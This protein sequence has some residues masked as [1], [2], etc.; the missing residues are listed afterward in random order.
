MR[1]LAATLAVALGS[2]AAALLAGA[3]AAVASPTHVALV[4][5]GQGSYCVRWFSG[6]TGDQVLRAEASVAYR[7]DG[8]LVQINGYPSSGTADNTHYWAYWHN[9]GRGWT[10]STE[11]PNTFT[12]QPGT[13]EGWAYDNG[14]STAPQPPA[15]SYSAICGGA[16]AP[17]PPPRSSSP[18]VRPTTASRARST[19]PAPPRTA[20]S[21]AGVSAA[22][23]HASSGAPRTSVA[24]TAA[25]ARRRSTSAT[26]SAAS[27][28][29]AATPAT[30]STAPTPAAPTR[31]GA[32]PSSGSAAPAA[33]G[34]GLAAVVAAGGGWAAW[35]RRR[36]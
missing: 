16:D 32:A 27:S 15:V 25:P 34:A 3:P 7:R 10:Y 31:A 35:R 1:R 33:A 24:A 4:I 28:T 20:T 12:P 29:T 13:V 11:G 26:T 17:P 14:G 36:G 30:T 8:V 22:S 6:I 23:A 9:T 18:V 2:G 21:S 5:A 19:A